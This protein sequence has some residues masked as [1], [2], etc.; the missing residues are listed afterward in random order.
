MIDEELSLAIVKYLG[1]GIEM[2]PKGDIKRV[3][4]EFGEK[5]GTILSHK[6]DKILD[7][8]DNLKPDWEKHSSDSAT[9]WAI[10]MMKKNTLNSTNK[11]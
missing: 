4:D 11:H 6:V 9:D 7:E 5:K 10:D 2:Y 3:I 8:L 1:V